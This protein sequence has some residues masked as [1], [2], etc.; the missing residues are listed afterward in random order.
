MAVGEQPRELASST[1]TGSG[2]GKH[3]L[4]GITVEELKKSAFGRSNDPSGVVVTDLELGSPAERAALRKDYVIREINGKPVKHMRDFERLT[5][6]LAPLSP[7]LL[8]LARENA[9][10]F[11]SISPRN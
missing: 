10:I 6:E 9:T 11:L 1:G 3:A 5:K 4:A 7:V 8:L 2:K